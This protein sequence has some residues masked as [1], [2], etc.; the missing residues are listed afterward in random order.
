MIRRR[1]LFAATLAAPAAARAAIPPV[2][3]PAFTPPRTGVQ[4]I[5]IDAGHGGDDSGVRGPGGTLEKQITLDV[6]R[7]LRTSIETRLGI[8][9]IMTR[10]DDRAVTLDERAAMANNGK[11][12]LFLS[13]HVNGS[14]S[15]AM[16]GA[17]VFT[18]LLDR[19]GEQVR[20]T[21]TARSSCPTSNTVKRSGGSRWLR[22]SLVRSAPLT[23]ATN[24][25][26]KT[27]A[28]TMRVRPRAARPASKAP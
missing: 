21:A 20:R 27:T 8:R 18:L 10:E 28:L 19:D 12:A 24:E 14:P 1:T 25:T 26:R 5:V 17:E 15:A 3:P 11:A 2:E 22:D 23:M 9:V 4:A 13:L 6:A 7:R 16:R